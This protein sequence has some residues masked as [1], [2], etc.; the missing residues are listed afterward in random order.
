MPRDKS[1][2]IRGASAW[3]LGGGGAQTSSNPS[4]LRRSSH[5][6]SVCVQ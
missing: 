1:R 4:R 2:N 6:S 3:R 5:C